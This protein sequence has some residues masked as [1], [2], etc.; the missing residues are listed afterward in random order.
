M[1]CRYCGT[2]IIG[3]GH[4]DIDPELFEGLVDSLRHFCETTVFLGGGTFFCHPQWEKLLGLLSGCDKAFI[5]DCPLD[6]NILNKI[7]TTQPSKFNYHP[8]ISLWGIDAVHDELCGRPSFHLLSSYIR[9][10]SE[11]PTPLRL[12]FVMSKN[13][14]QQTQNVIDFVDQ[15]PTG[16]CLYFHRLMPVGK[17]IHATLPSL[18]S[19]LC[20]KKRIV[21]QINITKTAKFHHTLDNTCR[22]E[23]NDRIFINH[24][25]AVH[26]CGWIDARSIP[27]CKLHK[28]SR[29]DFYQLFHKANSMTIQC[30]LKRNV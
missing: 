8:S 21:S 12:S 23:S 1:K 30:V 3:N 10:Q 20:F 22:A 26:K 7:Y 19:L 4:S 15:L 18:D 28:D 24:D 13:L 14:V 29:V 6:K 11:W 27:I 5:I 16:T 2:C 17:G 25:G 9:K